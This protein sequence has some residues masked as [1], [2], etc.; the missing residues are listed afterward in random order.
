MDQTNQSIEVSEDEILAGEKLVT[1]RLRNG[2]TANVTVKALSWR[3]ALQASAALAGGDVAGGTILI[4]NAAVAAEHRRDSFLDQ[5]TPQSLVKLSQTA[6][7]LSN[8]VAEKQTP[9]KEA[10]P[11]SATSSPLSGS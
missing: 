9:A 7:Q 4:V 5:V 1:L 2:K 10:A 6:L 3:I 11:A 8:G